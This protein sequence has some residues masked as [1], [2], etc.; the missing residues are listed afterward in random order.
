VKN[1]AQSVDHTK[2]SRRFFAALLWRAFPSPSERAL[3][4]KAAR[5]LDVSP[6]QVQNW[7]RCEHSAAWHYVAAVMAVA[8]AEVVFRRIEGRECD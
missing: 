7:L 6:R 4:E 1:P 5:V 3:S 8:G 2:A